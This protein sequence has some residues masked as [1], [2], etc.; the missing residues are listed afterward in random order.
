MGTLLE[1]TRF[2]TREIQRK[3]D[4]AKY[5]HDPGAWSDY[6]L[7]IRLWSK[8]AAIAKDVAVHK[9]V[10]VKAGH[11]V[12]KSFL[13]AILI[14]WW[15]DTRY[16]RVFVASTAPSTAQIGAIVWRYVRQLKTQISQRYKEGLIDHELP[17]YI[18]ADNQWKEVGGN[19]LGFGRKPPENKDDDAFQGLHDG[20]VLAIGDEAVGLKRDLIDA[21]GNIT[22]NEGC[23][24]LLICNPTNPAS[25]VG[26]IFKEEI[27]NWVRHTISVFDSPKFTGETE[28][29]NEEALQGMVD[30]SYPED[31]AVEW[32]K[33]SARYKA[34]VEG[35]FAWDLED[36]L[37][38]PEDVAR[39]V[40]NEIIPV[41]DTPVYLGVDVARFGKDKSVI[42]VNRG[43]QIRLY[44]D[45]D[46][47]S[48]VQLAAEVHL[49]AT[50]LGAHEVRY[51]VQGVGQG[52][53][54]LLLQHEPRTYR[55][56]GLAGSAAS[57]DRRQWFNAR[58]YWWDTFRKGLRA[59][60][61]DLDPDDEKLGDELIMVE[62]KFAPTGGL[63][64]E[65][66]DEMRKRGI[67][68]PDYADAAIYASVD[69]TE[70]LNP[71]PKKQTTYEDAETVTG[72]DTPHYLGLLVQ[73]W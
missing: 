51:D 11:G 29:L 61:Y 38:G 27:G 22:S 66:K 52:F 50:E 17:G 48:L 8:Q 46:Q 59:G 69:L 6:M 16:P 15:I 28:G 67:K 2:A 5:F 35:E 26:K 56:I 23:C 12:G 47:N 33:D 45:F 3:A 25:Y 14:C 13:A 54:E 64:I 36:V 40:D 19:I 57:P 58:A 37:I 7:G 30:Q 24:R 49:A 20:H 39:G 43:G 70:M 4:S 44:K 42:Y 1:A 62:Y 53:E 65:S 55:M 68:S 63:L 9:N 31:K 18:T 34:R 72:D 10:A 71:E 41:S 32:G 60:N 73:G 21:L